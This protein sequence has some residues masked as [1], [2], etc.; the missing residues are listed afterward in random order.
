MPP[1]GV[2]PKKEEHEVEQ[3]AD[4]KW[5]EFLAPE[6]R[7][8]L[9]EPLEKSKVTDIDRMVYEITC[10]KHK[11]GN[12]VERGWA[13]GPYTEDEVTQK[14]G[15]DKWVA[16]RS[17]VSYKKTSADKLTNSVAS[18]SMGALLLKN[19]SRWTE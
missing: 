8:E 10:G 15:N 19:A 11:G 7:G 17:S 18:L 9:K 4:P 13:D 6:L 16:A 2:F 3:G 12:E 5:L 14:L 1:T